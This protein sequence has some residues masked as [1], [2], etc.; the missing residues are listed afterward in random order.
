MMAVVSCLVHVKYLLI[1]SVVMHYSR[2]NRR[3]HLSRLVGRNNYGFMWMTIGEFHLLAAEAW[4]TASGPSAWRAL[5]S[6]VD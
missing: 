1:V 2:E 4:T 5:W 6:S 3:C